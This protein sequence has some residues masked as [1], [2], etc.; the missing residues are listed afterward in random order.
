MARTSFSM[1]PTQ[2]NHYKLVFSYDGTNFFGW[3]KT[4]PVLPTIEGALEN[5]LTTLLKHPITLQAASRTDRGVHALQQVAN[6][7][8]PHDLHPHSFLYSLNAILPADIKVAT[9]EKTPPDFHPTLDAVGKEYHYT[10][11]TNTAQS[12][13][14]RRYSW[15]LPSSPSLEL[16]DS[17]TE[18]LL[19]THDFSAFTNRREPAHENRVCTLTQFTP[20]PLGNGWIR[21]V[22]KG[23]RFL[24]KMV[25]NLVG[26][27]VYIGIGKLSYKDLPAILEGQDRT[28]AGM[29]APAS[30]LRLE[31]VFY[32]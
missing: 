5:A 6:F 1:A 19:G 18:V 10:L 32:S 4:D 15:H 21:F 27:V 11:C 16:M 12:P 24:Y 7:I 26:T 17:A 22:L 9:L 28:L 30:G 20:V 14:L 13:F 2:S 25:R 29:T 23:D 3:Q 8:T 31:R